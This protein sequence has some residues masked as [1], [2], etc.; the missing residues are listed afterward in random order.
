V[1]HTGSGERLMRFDG[2]GHGLTATGATGPNGRIGVEG[3]SDPIR[4][5]YAIG[6][7][8][9]VSCDHQKPGGGSCEGRCHDNLAAVA[10][11]IEQAFGPKSVKP[12]ENVGFGDAESGSDLS[13]EW[14]STQ[15]DRRS[16]DVMPELLIRKHGDIVHGYPP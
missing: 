16:V 13:G 2:E 3:G 7:V 11:K 6:E 4:V 9:A 8:R 1:R 15:F 10:R 5:P 12:L 14:R